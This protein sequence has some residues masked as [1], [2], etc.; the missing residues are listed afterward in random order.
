MKIT[1]PSPSIP[2]PA[3]TYHFF[4]SIAELTAFLNDVNRFA[5]ARPVVLDLLAQ[6]A[7]PLAVG[8]D[9]RVDHVGDRVLELRSDIAR[10]AEREQQVGDSSWRRPPQTFRS[11]VTGVDL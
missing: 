11:V 4:P 2:P 9:H 6:L 10:V 1:S 7:E 3:S 5:F 8:V